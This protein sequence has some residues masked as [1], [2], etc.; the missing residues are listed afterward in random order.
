MPLITFLFFASNVYALSGSYTESIVNDIRSSSGRSPLVR[1]T[2]LC[3][4]GAARAEEIKYDW[5]HSG[6]WRIVNY[7]SFTYWGENIAKWF[8]NEYDMVAAWMNSPTHRAN[9]LSNAWTYTCV[10][11]S[12]GYCVQLFAR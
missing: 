11:C 6:F 9:I 7:N 12:D 3:Q 8:T 5:S 1:S 2:Y 10:S 4:L